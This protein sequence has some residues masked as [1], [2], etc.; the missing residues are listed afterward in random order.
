M[1][2]EH[3]ELGDDIAHFLNDLGVLLSC[4]AWVRLQTFRL[5]DL[6]LAHRG[7][8]LRVST[9]EAYRLHG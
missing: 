5:E 3:C 6:G 7:S 8:G 4:A 2:S 1:A 9:A